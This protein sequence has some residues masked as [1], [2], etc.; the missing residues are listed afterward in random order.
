MAIKAYKVFS[1]DVK[2][3]ELTSCT[4]SCK[5]PRIIGGGRFWFGKKYIYS[6]GENVDIQC[7]DNDRGFYASKKIEFFGTGNGDKEIMCE[8][9]LYGRVIEHEEGY[10]AEKIKI[11]SIV[12][13][14]GIRFDVIKKLS[15]KYR[16]TIKDR[17]RRF[18]WYP[19]ITRFAT[20]YVLLN[21]FVY[22]THPL[23]YPLI[24]PNLDSAGDGLVS[25]V[26]NSIFWTIVFCVFI[27]IM[28][29]RNRLSYVEW[30]KYR[31]FIKK[32]EGKNENR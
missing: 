16:I 13:S 11:L 29:N 26:F 18:K 10:R 9:L 28:V 30:D 32:T 7:G 8:V 23:W 31:K 24:R 12:D 25:S 5:R 15:D 27:F 21:F 17:V 4:G 1:V 2:K 14:E 6:I 20:I 22:G 3:L 19:N